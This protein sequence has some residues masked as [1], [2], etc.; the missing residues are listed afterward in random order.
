MQQSTIQNRLL[1][2][3][4][5][6]AFREIA[7]DLEPVDLPRSYV[8]S[9]PLKDCRYS[10]FPETGI[11]S[12]VAVSPEGQHSEVGIFGR[13]G[14]TPAYLV[15]ETAMTPYSIFMQVPGA[16]HRLPNEK[17]LEATA[18][19]APLRR[20][21]LRYAYVLSIQ[22]A[23]TGLSNSIHHVDVRLARWLLMCH[24]RTRSDRFSLTH[25][26]LAVM[27]SVR[28]SSVTNALHMLEGNHLIYSER[29][30]ISIRDRGALE[31]FAGDAY[32]IPE[33]E[34]SRLIGK[35]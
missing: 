3:L 25:E 10:Y 33:A 15:L 13:E 4:P 7:D 30:L 28:R 14:M 1:G 17:L 31:D 27:L 24:D 34:Y 11:G 22:T 18:R 5:E 23:Y 20:L 2:M 9:E 6:E 19:S 12:I 26:F 16:G 32:G 8:F 21:L 35:I 29:S